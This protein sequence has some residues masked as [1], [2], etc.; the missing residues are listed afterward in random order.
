MRRATL[1][2]LTLTLG[3]ALAQNPFRDLAPAPEPDPEPTV[4]TPITID[5]P[6]A[7]LPA[8]PTS[9]NGFPALPAN[10]TYQ[11]DGTTSATPPKA[12]VNIPDHPVVLA[13]PEL[14]TFEH[15]ALTIA[16][17]NPLH[18]AAGT[19]ATAILAPL[20][21]P[22]HEEQEPSALP[23]PAVEEG[24]WCVDA[25]VLATSGGQSPTALI[26]CD[27]A[28]H[29]LR[30]GDLIPGTDASIE[31]IDPVSVTITRAN[32]SHQLQLATN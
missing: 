24:P 20:P 31:A 17:R 12:T 5:I 3:V 15:G 10:G 2:A 30:V 23:E 9:V 4:S 22:V 8:P 18:A 19:N 32:H 26:R 6:D 25:A 28:T 13:L 7:P 21:T 1:L 11:P 16:L 27:G 29:L 14:N